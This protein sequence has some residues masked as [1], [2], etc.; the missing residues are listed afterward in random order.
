MKSLIY[1][2]V[3]SKLSDLRA[4]INYTAFALCQLV[5]NKEKTP[6][7]TNREI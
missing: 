2:Y 7:R 4:N 1:W 6:E 3:A 5:L